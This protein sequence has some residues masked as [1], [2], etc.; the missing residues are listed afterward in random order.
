MRTRIKFCGCTDMQEVMMAIETGADAIGMIF[1]PSTRRITESAAKHIAE[2]LPPFITPV[3]V[4]VD[5]TRDDIA[6]AREIFPDLVIQLHGDESPSFVSSLDGKII[7][8][9]HVPP[10][11]GDSNA[12]ERAGNE[13]PRAI[14]LFDTAVNGASGG[15]GV[16]FPWRTIAPI[17]RERQVVVGG[18]LTPENVSAC[19]RTVRPYGVDVRSGIETGG[20][21]DAA[22]MRAFVQAVKETDAS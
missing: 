8:T 16:T 1:A 7:K 20:R 3:G 4:F 2:R 14:L 11:A 12:V 22:K 21:K 10:D 19:V 6:R 18:G 5:P 9:I 17:A 15:T 13:H